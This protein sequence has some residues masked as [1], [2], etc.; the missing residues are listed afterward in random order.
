MFQAYGRI[1]ACA[2]CSAV[3]CDS[4]FNVRMGIHRIILVFAVG[5]LI[6]QETIAQQANPA[7]QQGRGGRGGN[8]APEPELI[9]LWEQSAPGALGDSSSGRPTITF[10][11]APRGR[12]LKAPRPR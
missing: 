9:P 5:G 2:R 6:C 12:G 1:T 11:I 10:F 4:G 3:C 8:V 7:P